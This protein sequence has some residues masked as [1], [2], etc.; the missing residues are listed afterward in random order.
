M[1]AVTEPIPQYFKLR[2]LTIVDSTYNQKVTALNI[3]K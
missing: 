3:Q 2:K 1:D